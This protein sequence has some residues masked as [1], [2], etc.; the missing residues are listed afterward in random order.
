MHLAIG[1]TECKAAKSYSIDL[2]EDVDID[3]ETYEVLLVYYNKNILE[4]G[5]NWVN[6]FFKFIGVQIPYRFFNET[7]IMG[8]AAIQF[9][10]RRYL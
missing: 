6:Q 4:S 7:P 10:T 5:I 1:L 2:P 3:Q 9:N 8:W